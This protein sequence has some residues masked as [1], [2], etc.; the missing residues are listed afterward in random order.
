MSN[1]I[2]LFGAELGTLTHRQVVEH[3]RKDARNIYNRLKSIEEDSA[4]V[5]EVSAAFPDYPVIGKDMTPVCKNAHESAARVN[6]LPHLGSIESVLELSATANERCGRWYINPKKT[7]ATSVY[8]KS[9]DGHHGAWNFN[10][11]RANTQLFDVV[12]NYTGKGKLMPDSFTKTVPIWC[13]TWNQA[14]RRY[15]VENANNGEASHYSAASHTWDCE[16]HTPPHLVSASEHSQISELI[17]GFVE[18]LMSSGLDIK[19]AAMATTRPLRPIW[20]TRDQSR[21]MFPDFTDANFFP[22][23]CVSVSKAVGESAEGTENR[24]GYLYVQGSADDH[25][26]WSMGLSPRLFWKHSREILQDAGACEARV[27]EVVRKYQGCSVEGFESERI[28]QQPWAFVEGTKLAIGSRT[29]GRPPECWSSFAAVINCGAPQYEANTVPALSG[30]YMY[31]PIP[32]GKKGQEALAKYIPEALELA[33][34]TL[35]KDEPLLVHWID[36]SVGI[37]LAILTKY[38]DEDRIDKSSIQRRLMWIMSS[39]PKLSDPSWNVIR[40]YTGQSFS[41]MV[42]CILLIILLNTFVHLTN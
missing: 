1:R 29:S 25:E 22:I 5:S 20:I 39:W 31:L 4:F 34:K 37:A 24:P 32:E 36:R 14:I 41:A 6:T 18:R 2:D 11:R 30:R 13:A 10:L 7:F 17:S 26:L 21:D 42:L 35:G 15:M 40:D 23:I 19:K 8:F 33:A 27:R 12:A 16:L 38:F 9:T 28:S 3:L